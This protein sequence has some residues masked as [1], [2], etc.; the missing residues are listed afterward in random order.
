M[1]NNS[2]CPCLGVSA[3][4]SLH[5]PDEAS[6]AKSSGKKGP[7]PR[8]AQHVRPSVTSQDRSDVGKHL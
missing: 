1:S 6:A 3:M 7:G 4:D 2:K 8:G 5:P